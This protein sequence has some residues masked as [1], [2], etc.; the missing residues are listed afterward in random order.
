MSACESEPRSSSAVWQ[1]W[2]LMQ[3][4]KREKE[5]IHIII[6]GIWTQ[7]LWNT[8]PAPLNY[9]WAR[10]WTQH[11]RVEASLHIAHRIKASDN[12]SCLSLSHSFYTAYITLVEIPCRQNY[13]PGWVKFTSTMPEWTLSPSFWHNYLPTHCHPLYN[14]YESSNA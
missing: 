12:S 9:H 1:R 11:R 5:W 14:K 10:H 13:R 6:L 4:S 7:D 3:A 8:S 2:R